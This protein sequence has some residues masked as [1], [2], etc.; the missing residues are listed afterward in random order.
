[1]AHSRRSGWLFTPFLSGR[2]TSVLRRRHRNP[3]GNASSSASRLGRNW[4]RRGKLREDAAKDTSQL[5]HG[6][7]KGARSSL[8][9][10][11]KADSFAYGRHGYAIYSPV[12]VPTSR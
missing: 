3:S 12:S 2:Q 11:A 4:E 5:L 10:R 6:R 8:Y 9:V 1:M 7:T